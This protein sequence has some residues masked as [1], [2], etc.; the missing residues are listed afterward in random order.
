MHSAPSVVFPVGRCSFYAGAL[1]MLAT[2]G[3]WMLGLWWWT[4]ADSRSIWW[5]WAGAAAWL[6]W[7]SFA[8]RSWLRSPIGMLAWNASARSDLAARAGTWLWHSALCPEGAPLRRVEMVL[9]LQGRALLRLH[10]AD[11]LAR[12][13][14]V[15]RSR[16]PARWNELR[17]ALV[18]A[19]V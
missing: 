4:V 3:A 18:A 16:D 5:G 15:E 2:S 9:D 14:W 7:G 6:A 13:I 8:A 1:V 11:A 19:R 10:N 12:W 17:R